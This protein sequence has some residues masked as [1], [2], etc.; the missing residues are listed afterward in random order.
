VPYLAGEA[1]E[2]RGGGDPV[3]TELFGSRA[4]RRGEW[5]VTDLGDG[6]WRLFN[7]AE[8][9]GETKNLAGQHPELLRALS[10]AWDDYARQ[11]GVILPSEVRYRP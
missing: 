1:R 5:K 3:G 2:V 11:N 10:Q 4:L 6:H 7:V 9:P 8:D